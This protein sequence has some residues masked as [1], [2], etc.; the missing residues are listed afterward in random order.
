LS[1]N[2]DAPLKTLKTQTV[3]VGRK[4]CRRATASGARVAGERARA[5]R[6]GRR[7]SEAGQSARDSELVARFRPP[8][9]LPAPFPSVEPSTVVRPLFFT[10][11]PMELPKPSRRNTTVGAY[12]LGEEIGKGAHGQVYKAIDTRDGSM[13]AVKEIALRRLDD[14]ARRALRLEIELLTEL[15]AHEN[16][17][18]LR[19]VVEHD[20]YVYVVLELAE[21]GSLASLVK[22]AKF[23]VCAEPLARVYVRQILR[24]LEYL[25]ARG[26]VHRD[27]KGANVLT[28][29]DGVVKIAD[30]GV[31]LRRSTLPKPDDTVTDET[32]TSDLDVQGTPYWMA[33]EAIEMRAGKAVGFASDV[34]SVA[35]VTLELLTGA[36][37]YFDMQPMPA[38]FAIVNND[39]PPLPDGVSAECR[40]FLK[41]CFRKDPAKRPSARDALAHAWLAEKDAFS[42]SRARK[43]KETSSPPPSRALFPRTADGSNG[44]S[45]DDSD[46]TD[47]SRGDSEEEPEWSAPPDVLA[48]ARRRRKIPPSSPFQDAPI[49]DAAIL[50]DGA[51]NVTGDERVA[52]TDKNENAR[53]TS[54][55]SLLET[56]L[57][58]LTNDARDAVTGAAERLKRFLAEIEAASVL[59]G[60]SSD[61][62]RTHLAFSPASCDSALERAATADVAAALLADPGTSAAEA[63]DALDAV[64]AAVSVTTSTRRDVRTNETKKN[65]GRF[66]ASFCLLGGVRSTL[67]CLSTAQDDPASSVLRASAAKAAAALARA[68]GVAARVVASCGALEAIAAFL[69][70]S[71]NAYTGADRH[72]VRH[73]LDAAFA[74]CFPNEIRFRAGWMEATS[75]AFAFD[76]SGVSGVSRLEIGGV[77]D[78]PSTTRTDERAETNVF[79]LGFDETLSPYDASSD[80][81]TSACVA[82][83]AAAR[84]GL[85]PALARLL[86]ALNVAARE[87]SANRNRSSTNVRSGDVSDEDPDSDPTAST[88][89]GRARDGAVWALSR[90]V[91]AP[92]RAGALARRSVFSASVT[93]THAFLGVVG[94]PAMPPR[95][96]RALLRA[97]RHASRDPA[98]AE[99]LRRAGATPKLARCLQR[100]DAEARES[101]MRALRNVCLI[102]E[103]GGS[104]GGS[105]QVSNQ[106]SLTALEH[107]AVAGA[108]PHLVAVAVG[109]DPRRFQTENHTSGAARV[110]DGGGIGAGIATGANGD[111]A[112]WRANGAVVSSSL[113]DVAVETLCA[114]ASGGSRTCRA[115]LKEAGALEALA[116]LAF[117]P[118][119]DTA[120]AASGASGKRRETKD[121]K[122]AGPSS[123]SS[124]SYAYAATRALG[125][126]LADEPWIVEARL[127]E[128]DVVE[129]A[130]TAVAAVAAGGAGA[131]SR[132]RRT[133]AAALGASTVAAAVDDATVDALA[134]AAARSPRWSGALAA[135][136]VADATLASLEKLVDGG[137]TRENGVHETYAVSVCGAVASR[138]RLLAAVGEC[139]PKAR[140]WIRSARAAERTDELAAKCEETASS[141]KCVRPAAAAARDAAARLRRRG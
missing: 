64:A 13:V 75:D 97:L 87:E 62:S 34:W 42:P 52:E 78:G 113:R 61:A 39:R 125:A 74:L 139:D 45:D 82:S 49:L 71:P 107:A 14:K 3:F 129:A 99:G 104:N 63:A 112:H 47:D 55:V 19:G 69:Q 2:N 79:S 18:A 20:A 60:A 30:F 35:C 137:T 9:T 70:A 89:S 95:A 7:A 53:Q 16:V 11:R 36:P 140:E 68:G 123:V 12:V 24:G 80:G 83:G 1:V 90:L 56:R 73:A 131:A 91:A 130:V 121:A 116:S 126:W 128:S 138:A 110:T 100:G 109:D 108:T 26:V 25:H 5:A 37:P 119:A 65:G 92:G 31:A 46:A 50:D 58:E 33:P 133:A 72:A 44:S 57:V 22:P 15:G 134:E 135:G 115:K 66:A 96:T 94:S 40:D 41:R 54:D 102:G 120:D 59:N 8:V 141:L 23:G 101:A 103:N 114:A 10:P 136:G 86:A 124:I 76:G 38:M 77:D 27:V 132:R 105:N 118:T 17:I 106:V 117:P 21:N 48:A 84:A 29:K 122:D 93:A 6:A 111:A 43:K 85:A 4:S 51:T 32:D 67:A 88:P 81:V 127:M 28:T 98:A